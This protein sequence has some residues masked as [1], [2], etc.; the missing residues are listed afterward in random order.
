MDLLMK[1]QI[2]NCRHMGRHKKH[3]P[4]T[5]VPPEV[6]LSYP[7]KKYPD[8]PNSIPR[9]YFPKQ[10]ISDHPDAI[11]SKDYC[12]IVR[13]YCRYLALYL[14]HT[15]KEFKIPSGIGSLQFVKF[16]PKGGVKHVDW[17]R[18]NEYNRNLAPNEKK[19]VFKSDL[20][21]SH[22]YMMKLKWNKGKFTK[23]LLW[24]TIT[25][26]TIKKMLYDHTKKGNQIFKYQDIK[27]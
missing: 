20:R 13:T 9:P 1:I 15:G 22:G 10:E 27:K 5:V 24:K 14:V 7:H 17:K 25:A 3:I 18:T 2:Y 11:T 16:K 19:K 4:D 26:I 12:N 6:F 8:N 21:W 23:R